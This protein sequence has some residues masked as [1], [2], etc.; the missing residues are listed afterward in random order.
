MGYNY[1]ME[2]KT[3]AQTNPHLQ[4]PQK[5]LRQ[6]VRS[7]ASSTAIETGQTIEELEKKILEVFKTQTPLER[8]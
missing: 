7:I 2:K 4:D 6:R 5:A 1:V 3:L 8:S